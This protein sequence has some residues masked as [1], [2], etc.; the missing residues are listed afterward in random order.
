MIKVVIL[1]S[2]GRMAVTE[3]QKEKSQHDVLK[4]EAKYLLLSM[5]FKPSEIFEEYEV[6]VNSSKK[7]KVDVVGIGTK[8]VAIEC[9]HTDAL[10]ISILNFFFD[11]II[12]LPF[13]TKIMS[14]ELQEELLNKEAKIRELKEKISKLESQTTELQYENDR[15]SNHRRNLNKKIEELK[16]FSI[17]LWKSLATLSIEILPPFWWSVGDDNNKYDNLKWA[18]FREFVKEISS[19]KGDTASLKRDI[20]QVSGK[21]KKEFFEK[22]IN[23][24]K[25]NLPDPNWEHSM[26]GRS[27]IVPVIEHKEEQTNSKISKE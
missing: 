12:L 11:E 7:F 2:G 15:E 18:A 6:M 13:S 1:L 14:P 27:A 17:Y 8:K 5:G 22:I 4:E 19:I 10:K 26:Y 23:D 3:G 16:I 25:E 20:E 24:A 21:I 9:G